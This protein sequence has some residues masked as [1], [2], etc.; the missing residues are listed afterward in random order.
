MPV[1]HPSCAST[2]HSAIHMRCIESEHRLDRGAI[3]VSQLGYNCGNDQEGLLSIVCVSNNEWGNGDKPDGYRVLGPR[4]QS[5]T[6][7]KEQEKKK[8][9]KK[10]EL[11]PRRFFESGPAKPPLPLYSSWYI[12]M[13]SS[14]RTPPALKAF[15]WAIC[16][17]N[18]C[19]WLTTAARIRSK[20]SWF[21]RWTLSISS[22][23]C[24]EGRDPI[25][26]PERWVWCALVA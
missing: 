26:G 23:S 16:S 19:S 25:T 24:K 9:R 14:S 7:S 11:T 8:K 6:E 3:R 1:W 12:A 21:R 2:W 10:G 18:A 17:A 22:T 20:A 4:T 5:P 15:L 13:W